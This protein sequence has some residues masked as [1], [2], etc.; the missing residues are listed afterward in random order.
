MRVAFEDGRTAVKLPVGT[1]GAAGREMAGIEVTSTKELV[2]ITVL[3]SR[4]VVESST[5]V[6]VGSATETGAEGV[7]VGMKRDTVREYAAAHSVRS[8]PSGQQNVLSAPS[9]VQVYPSSQP[10]D[11]S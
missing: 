7:S 11:K 9:V 1:V 5:D 4:M 2:S 3:V 6:V 10:T 8:M